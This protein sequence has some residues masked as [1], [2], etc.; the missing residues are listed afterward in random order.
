M[1]EMKSLTLNGKQYDS[2]LD[3]AARKELEQKQPKGNYLTEH[4]KL[5]T[6]N[7]QSLV[8]DGDVEIPGSAEG[9]VLYTEQDL[10]PEQQEQARQNIGA[11]S[12]DA[13][14]SLSTKQIN[15]LDAL[16]KVAAYTED[17]SA[18]YK[19]F[20]DAFGL[21][22]PNEPS[23]NV[24]VQ[25][26]KIG[27]VSFEG[28]AMKLSTDSDAR[29]TLV[30]I[31]QYLKNGVTYKFSLG[32]L[33]GTYN[34]GIQ[35]M[36]AK[37]AG[38]TFP[39]VGVAMTYDGVTERVVDSGYITNDY[40][41]EP[42]RDNCILAV[43]F[44]KIDGTSMG[45]SDYATILENFTIEETAPIAETSEPAYL[46]HRSIGQLNDTSMSISAQEN[47]KR[48]AVYSATRNA[49]CLGFHNGTAWGS[50]DYSP[51]KIPAGA[52]TAIVDVPSTMRYGA[53]I[54]KQHDT[55]VMFVM[56]VVD[57][58]WVTDGRAIDVSG[59]NDGNHYLAANVA[60][61]SDAEIPADFDTSVLDVY[62]VDAN[63]N[64]MP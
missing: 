7:G 62:F 57:S 60:Y 14:I 42:D 58:G 13:T 64:R 46:L 53:F 45:D 38:I 6:I 55:S 26:I 47:P 4:Q 35:V 49:K 61:I 12:A 3:Q 8:G 48:L 36:V 29:A 30:P 56:V 22:N 5:K 24:V 51:L 15:A 63:G 16:F 33:K 31:G 34:Y 28:G 20:C 10:T 40:V 41:D 23:E 32:S 21:T 2:F 37:S 43:N 27:S 54:A 50:S 39:Y 59:Y 52:M 25:A 11:M 44:K 9:A 17:A 18:A 19:A 1:N